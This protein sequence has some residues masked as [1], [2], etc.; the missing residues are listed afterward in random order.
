MSAE[1]SVGYNCSSHSEEKRLPHGGGVRRGR[2]RAE[3]IGVVS[4][5]AIE[6]GDG[7]GI[8]FQPES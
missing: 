3:P 5:A 8:R 4:R 7:G 1:R 6:R 2:K